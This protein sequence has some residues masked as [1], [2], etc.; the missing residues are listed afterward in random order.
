MR[1]CYFLSRVRFRI[2][3]MRLDSSGEFDSPSTRYVDAPDADTAIERGNRLGLQNKVL[4][5]TPV[6]DDE[7]RDWL[8]RLCRLVTRPRRRL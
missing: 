1:S 8:W 2:D 6:P 4:G 7:G 5:I 3:Y